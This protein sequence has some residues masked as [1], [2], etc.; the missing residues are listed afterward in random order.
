MKNKK[1]I[2]YFTTKNFSTFSP[3]LTKYTP[4]GRVEISIRK[5]NS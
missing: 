2:L 3:I 1:V 5:G 4:D